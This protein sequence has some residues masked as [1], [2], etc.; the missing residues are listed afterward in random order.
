M[1]IKEQLIIDILK[2]QNP[3]LIENLYLAFREMMNQPI[4]KS[5][6]QPIENQEEDEDLSVW[7]DIIE[8]TYKERRQSAKLFHHK[9]DMLFV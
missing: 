6:T 7:D 3:Q 4:Y 5:S 1:T 8:D 2:L 9:I